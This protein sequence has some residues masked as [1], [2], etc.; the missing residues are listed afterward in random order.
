MSNWTSNR[1]TIKGLKKDLNAFVADGKKHVGDERYENCDYSFGSWMPIPETYLKYD[2]ANHPYGE[3]LVVG[4]PVSVFD[5]DSPIVTEELIEEYKK[6]SIAQR[7]DYGA[8]GILDWCRK[9]YGCKWDMGFNLQRPD[10]NTVIIEV[11]TPWVH[12]YTFLEHMSRRYPSLSFRIQ[13]HYEDGYNYLDT[14]Q[15]GVV[16]HEDTDEF[17]AKVA[18]YITKRVKEDNSERAEFLLRFL[19]NEY[20]PEG[21]WSVLTEDLEK[22]YEHFIQLSEYFQEF[23]DLPSNK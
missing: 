16:V 9:Y 21:Y 5:D 20:M 18:E 12:P 2:T 11:M 8:I 6:A 19:E 1:I 10:N 23:S 4:K 14:Y 3:G 7:L 22:E 17:Q 13:A 15:N